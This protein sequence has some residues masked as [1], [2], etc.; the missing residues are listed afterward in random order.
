MLIFLVFISDVF[1]FDPE[2]IENEEKYKSVAKGRIL[3]LFSLLHLK[4][5]NSPVSKVGRKY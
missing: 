3:F 5:H 1:K 4:L 2:Y